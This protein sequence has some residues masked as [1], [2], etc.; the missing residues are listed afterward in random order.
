MT[1]IF[2]LFK[3]NEVAYFDGSSIKYYL[4]D[5]SSLLSYPVHKHLLETQ[6]SYNWAPFF[7]SFSPHSFSSSLMS[8]TL[9]VVN[10]YRSS[11]HWYAEDTRMIRH[12]EW[13]YLTLCIW[14]LVSSSW[15]SWVSFNEYQASKFHWKHLSPYFSKCLPL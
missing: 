9:R 3:V 5:P 11:W 2:L 4:L 10:K 12:S 13:R 14:I 8:I 7:W 6:C 15:S 1:H